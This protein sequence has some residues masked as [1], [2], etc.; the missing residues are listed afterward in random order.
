MPNYI[1]EDF[2]IAKRQYETTSKIRKSAKDNGTL[3]RTFRD[4]IY[5]AVAYKDINASN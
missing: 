4:R 1:E 2:K 5:G 3:Y